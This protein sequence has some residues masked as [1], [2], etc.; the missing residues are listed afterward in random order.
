[1]L[2]GLRAV[3]GGARHPRREQAGDRR[4]AAHGLLLLEDRA[5]GAHAEIIP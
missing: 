4:H 1:V 3:E 5:H 2:G